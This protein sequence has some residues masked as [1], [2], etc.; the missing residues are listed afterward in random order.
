[1]RSAK[2]LLHALGV[3]GAVLED[4]RW[5]ETAKAPRL[6]VSVRPVRDERKRCS[7]CGRRCRG[8]DRGD[9]LRTWRAPD[10]G[11]SE[12]LIEAKS[13]RVVCREHGVVV[14][15]VPWARART[16]FTRAFEDL[17]AWL[18]VKTDR[19]ALA[20]LLRVAWRSVGKVLRRVLTDER[21]RVDVFANLE[22][23]GIDEIS[24][25]KNHCYLTVVVNHAT[26]R[27]VWAGPWPRRQ[28]ASTLLRRARPRAH[29]AH[30]ARQRRR[31]LLDHRRR[32]RA[33][34]DGDANDGSV[35]RRAVG[36]PRA[37]PMSP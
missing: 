8:Y 33:M 24:Y 17:I 11:L 16:G 32:P 31:S 10:F 27:L 4:V 1:M 21:K 35:P 29:G 22:R 7:L 12:V 18:A 2:M 28:Y 5:E 6:V 14:A 25:K 34:P 30:Q 26:G 13:P 36:D 9:G 37:R 23:I 20:E 15:R 19:S 3:E